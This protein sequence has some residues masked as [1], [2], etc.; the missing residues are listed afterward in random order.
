MSH[1][2]HSI[3]QGA[4]LKIGGLTLGHFMNSGEAL[5][6][7]GTAQTARSSQRCGLS[8]TVGTFSFGHDA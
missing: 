4:I 5:S 8:L 3:V 7:E 2:M 1:G 6:I